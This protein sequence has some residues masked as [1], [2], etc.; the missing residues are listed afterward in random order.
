MKHLATLLLACASLVLVACQG[1]QGFTP[2]NPPNVRQLEQADTTYREI[3]EGYNRTVEHFDKLFL[4]TYIR[5]AWQETGEDGQVR[6]RSEAGDGKFIFDAPRST[7]LTVEKLSRIYLW[8]GSNDEHYWLFDQ[9]DEGYKVAY[10][11]RHDAAST[12]DA[13]Y[14]P[15]PFRPDDVP[16]LLGLLPLDPGL[17][18]K[19]YLY[20][21][22]YLIEP[23]GM[24]LRMLVDPTSFR[25]T[26]VD[27][28]DEAGWSIVTC[29]LTGRF[30]V[31]VEGVNEN[32]LPVVCDDADVFVS[33]QAS[34]MSIELVHATTN[35]RRV[36][37]RMFDLDVLME[38]LKPDAVIDLD[39]PR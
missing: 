19:V 23:E 6:Y 25:P 4:R 10:L 12:P 18:S 28:L 1:P 9:I 24:R 26:R 5:L 35:P 39:A 17:A 3:A 32:A 15:L 33:G 31:E 7:V 8:A 29:R 21:G 20:D 34:R 22:Q 38:A 13:R 16:Y 36:Q 37:D 30:G 14:L 2:D 27:L 11:G